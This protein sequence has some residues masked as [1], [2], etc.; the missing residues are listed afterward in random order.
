MTTK[1]LPTTVEPF[2]NA[3]SEWKVHNTPK[4]AVALVKAL[5]DLKKVLEHRLTDFD[6]TV[7]RPCGFFRSMPEHLTADD[8]RIDEVFGKLVIIRE[9]WH[10]WHAGFTRFAHGVSFR[11]ASDIERALD[12]KHYSD[13]L[14]ERHFVEQ[15]GIELV[16]RT[17]QEIREVGKKIGFLKDDPGS[18]RN[19]EEEIE[20]FE[21]RREV[22][23]KELEEHDPA[24]DV[25]RRIIEYF[26]KLPDTMRDLEAAVDGVH[27]TLIETIRS[28]D[29]ILPVIDKATP[30]VSQTL[31][32]ITAFLAP[33]NS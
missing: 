11:T 32:D 7:R 28:I 3:V 8:P 4:N 5:I 33:N 2:L 17:I 10:S 31:N 6:V 14:K 9:G 19:A 30:R 12:T 16:N 25:K 29:R 24:K 13:L 18:V 1:P 21:R 23:K 26:E 27:D 22:L 15:E 20:N